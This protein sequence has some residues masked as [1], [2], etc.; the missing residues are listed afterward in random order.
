MITR[1][2]LCA[3]ACSSLAACQSSAP[4][5]PIA[6]MRAFWE[7]LDFK[8]AEDRG[9]VPR[10][11]RSSEVTP[12]G[13]PSFINA[14]TDAGLGSSLAIGNRQGVGVAFADLTGDGFADIFV[15]NGNSVALRRSSGSQ[16]FVNDQHGKFA[17]ATNKAG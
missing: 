7:P 5:T 11:A 12:S 14:T 16:L 15:A 8:K 9:F 6:A 10:R 3:L 13:P 1:L 4:A 2:T 17:D